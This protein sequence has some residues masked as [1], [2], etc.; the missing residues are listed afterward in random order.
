MGT[1]LDVFYWQEE[2]CFEELKAAILDK[3]T[4]L[5]SAYLALPLICFR[6]IAEKLPCS[7]DEMMQIDQ[8]LNG[9]S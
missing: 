8:V 4:K 1:K 5:K 3:Y 9:S 7:K 6:E 2:A